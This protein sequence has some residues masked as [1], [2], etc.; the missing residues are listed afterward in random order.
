MPASPAVITQEM[1]AVMSQ[2]MQRLNEFLLKLHHGPFLDK[3]CQS[4]NGTYLRNKPLIHN[5][6]IAALRS[7]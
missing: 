6:E 7:Q 4:S 3:W 2:G 1:Q 5:H